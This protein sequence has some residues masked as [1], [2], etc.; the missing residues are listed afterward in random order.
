M[1]V[2]AELPHASPWHVI[3]IADDVRRLVESDLV[4]SLNAPCA[5]ADPSWIKPGKTTFPWWKFS[6]TLEIHG[7]I[8]TYGVHGFY[9]TQDLV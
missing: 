9:R 4:L 5:I 7:K 8:R 6:V 1:A 2:R 3:L